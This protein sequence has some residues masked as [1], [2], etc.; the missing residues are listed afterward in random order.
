MQESI[1]SVH[2]VMYLN[3]VPVL[4]MN[5]V[6][7]LQMITASLYIQCIVF[8]L[9]LYRSLEVLVFNFLNGEVVGLFQLFICLSI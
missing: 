9:H 5:D 7:K 6:K 8:Q 1:I 3:S 2:S 4:K